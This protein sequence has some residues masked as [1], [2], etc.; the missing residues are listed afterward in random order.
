MTLHIDRLRDLVYEICEKDGLYVGESRQCR[1]LYNILE[2]ANVGCCLGGTVARRLVRQHR[3][4][5]F[6]C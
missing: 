1:R 6:Q 4:M 2:V 5:M 3:K